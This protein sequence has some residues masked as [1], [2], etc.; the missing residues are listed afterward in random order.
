MDCSIVLSPEFL[1]YCFNPPLKELGFSDKSIVAMVF[2]LLF[3]LYVC[4]GVLYI[5][6][7]NTYSM[8]EMVFTVNEM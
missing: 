6:L 4:L 3:V 2:L 8:Q 1:L 5:Y 7:C